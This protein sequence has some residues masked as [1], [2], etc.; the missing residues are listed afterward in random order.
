MNY[1]RFAFQPTASP[2][3]PRVASGR[4]DRAPGRLVRAI[5][6]IR[7]LLAPFSAEN[8]HSLLRAWRNREVAP[9]RSCTIAGSAKL[10]ESV[11]GCPRSLSLGALRFSQL[12]NDVA[13]ESGMRHRRP[14]S[15]AEVVEPS[16]RSRLNSFA[17]LRRHPSVEGGNRRDLRRARCARGE[18]IRVLLRP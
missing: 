6:D 14:S 2:I 16:R 15:R 17:Q 11:A 3:I 18:H 7:S 13:P 10:E 1:R 12:R 9:K 8:T 5:G 4:L